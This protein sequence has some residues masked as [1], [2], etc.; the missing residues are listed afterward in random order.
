[1]TEDQ[2][3]KMGIWDS[4]QVDSLGRKK[5]SQW[6]SLTFDLCALEAVPSVLCSTRTR[7]LEGLSGQHET[8]KFSYN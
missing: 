4:I 3:R 7:T 1:M 8:E 6:I 2:S 5:H